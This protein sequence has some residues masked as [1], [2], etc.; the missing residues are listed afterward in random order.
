MLVVV[1]M[2]ALFTVLTPGLL[3]RFPKNGSK[4]ATAVVH[5]LAFVVIFCLTQRFVSRMGRRMGLE[6]FQDAPARPMP[7]PTPPMEMPT[8]PMPTPA[9]PMPMPAG[10]VPMP[11]Q[12]TV[13]ISGGSSLASMN[14]ILSTGSG[15]SENPC[16][17]GNDCASGMCMANKCM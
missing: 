6:G 4:L 15:K 11:T 16:V 1:Y 8:A 2:A 7:P 17:N 5:G 10:P 9:A 14:I 3:V 13:S 12:P